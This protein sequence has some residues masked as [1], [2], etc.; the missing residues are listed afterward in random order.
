MNVVF[1]VDIEITLRRNQGFQ[2]KKADD[3]WGFGQILAML[4]VFMP[5]RDLLETMVR[6]R[7]ELETKLND[8]LRGLIETKANRLTG[9]RNQGLEDVMSLIR[10]GADPNTKSEGK[11]MRPYDGCGMIIRHPF[12]QM[13]TRL[14]NWH[15]S[16]KTG[17]WF[18]F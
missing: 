15:A 12:M 14:S 1:I 3:D 11:S 2:D 8:R 18:S 16:T 6:R 9:D 5:L 4:L 17:K 13:A 7:Q 10:V